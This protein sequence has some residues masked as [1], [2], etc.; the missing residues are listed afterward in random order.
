MKKWL[1]LALLPLLLLAQQEVGAT[2]LDPKI[3]QSTVPGDLGYTATFLE[4]DNNQDGAYD[5][6]NI[7]IL[8]GNSVDISMAKRVEQDNE[9]PSPP[10][11]D[12]APNVNN[13][14]KRS[15]IRF[16]TADPI[17]T[18]TGEI[19]Y[20]TVL[21]IVNLMID[22]VVT[23]GLLSPG[24]SGI[25]FTLPTDN[26]PGKMTAY[27]NVSETAGIDIGTCSR[28]SI[29][30]EEGVS[31]QDCAPINPVSSVPVA[32]SFMLVGIGLMALGI[33]R[34]RGRLS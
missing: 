12:L 19:M 15:L 1:M 27:I 22:G 17:T 2:A 6:V 23:Q 18:S 31:T 14:N 10:S 28:M 24:L 9:K 26:T 11:S 29:W 30:D 21:A 32:N 25:S 5:Y 13:P 8:F 7:E 4:K 20:S 34:R 3:S 16:T 33:P